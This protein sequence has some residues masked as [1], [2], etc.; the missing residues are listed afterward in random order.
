MDLRNAEAHQHLLTAL[1][2][3]DDLSARLHDLQSASEAKAPTLY[4]SVYESLTTIATALCA[5]G[6]CLPQSP[7]PYSGV[8]ASSVI[9]GKIVLQMPLP[10]R[11]TGRDSA[12]AFHGAVNGM[13]LRELCP[14]L[15]DKLK[16][17]S[18][19]ALTLGYAPAD[20]ANIRHAIDH[21]NYY[22]KPIIDSVCAALG[23]DDGGASLS[24]CNYLLP[25]PELSPWLYAVVSPGPDCPSREEIIRLCLNHKTHAG[26]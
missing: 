10:K 6:D 14:Q 9:D 20:P 25:V 11:R 21:D 24:L 19:N 22:I 23:I 12:Y 5:Y 15:T 4:S 26:S 17:E 1:A 18:V 16:L 3:V 13:L 2:S 8:A 7:V